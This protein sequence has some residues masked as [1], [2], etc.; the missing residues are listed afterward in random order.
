MFGQVEREVCRI[1]R[2]GQQHR[3]RS[4]GDQ[5]VACETAKVFV[6]GGEEV[7]DW[8]SL[9]AECFLDGDR[10]CRWWCGDVPGAPVVVLDGSAA[11]QGEPQ[12]AGQDGSRSGW[13]DWLSTD[14]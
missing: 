9:M 7:A 10:G 11:P 3:Q 13:S 12:G 2:D 8:S 14:S 5:Q 4:S 6:D 1:C